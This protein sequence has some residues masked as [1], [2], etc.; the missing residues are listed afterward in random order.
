M[1]RAFC[2]PSLHIFYGFAVKME[3]D[4]VC[5]LVCL[6]ASI[7]T[8]VKGDSSKSGKT[9]DL[10]MMEKKHRNGAYSSGKNGFDAFRDDVK[11]LIRNGFRYVYLLYFLLK[12]FACLQS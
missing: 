5:G 10:S 8:E 7:A 1:R 6:Q 2:V 12:D 4:A 3:D 11:L 9:I